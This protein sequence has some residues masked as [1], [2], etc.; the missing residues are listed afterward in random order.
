MSKLLYGLTLAVL[1]SLGLHAQETDP[2]SFSGRYWFDTGY[3]FQTFTPGNL[4][5]S[6]EDLDEGFHTFN[7]YITDGTE[8]SSTHSKW[9]FKKGRKANEN[10]HLKATIY[11][12]G[13]LFST[14]EVTVGAGNII[15]FAL[16]MNAVDLGTHTLGVI[17]TDANGNSLGYRNSVFL[18]VPTD[19]Q[20]STFLAYYYIDNE[21]RGTA[22]PTYDGTVMHLDIDAASLETGLHFLTLYMVSPHGMASSVRSSWFIKIPS[23]GEGIKQYSY[24]LNDNPETLTT[25]NLPEVINPCQVMSLIEIPE[26]PFRSKS[27]KFEI[28]DNKPVY[29]AC[30]D[31]NIRFMDPDSRVSTSSRTY[32]DIRTKYTPD[33]ITSLGLN[34]RINTGV[35]EKD[36]IKLFKFDAE[37]GDSINTSCAKAA[38]M[39]IYS[40]SGK[41]IIQVQ[42]IKATQNCSMTAR[43]NGTY[44]LAVHDV[45]NGYSTELNFQHIHKFALLDQNVKKSADKGCFEMKVIG[46]GFE[47]L[48]SLAIKGDETE[49]E[50]DKFKVV[51]NNTLYVMIDFDQN[52]VEKGPYRLKGIF[53]DNDKKTTEEI[54]SSTALE[55]ESS[56]PV[57]INVRIDTP[58]I[59]S[60][61]Y[62]AYIHVTNNSNVGV[63]GVPFNLAAE[64]TGREGKI[65]FMDFGISVDV[66][67]KDSI[68][69]VYYTENLLNT[70]KS[71][72]FAPTIIPYLAPGETKTYTLGFTTKAHE[73]VNLYAWTGTPWSESIREMTSEN[74]DLSIIEQPF[75]GNLFTFQEACKIFYQWLSGQDTTEAE[76]TKEHNRYA[77][78]CHPDPNLR[79]VVN[80]AAGATKQA[81]GLAASSS[82]N[83]ISIRMEGYRMLLEGCGSNE[84]VEQMLNTDRRMLMVGGDLMAASNTDNNLWGNLESLWHL[85]NARNHWRQ[86]VPPVPT[87]SYTAVDC[88][89]SGDPNDITG[90]VSPSGTNHIGIDVKNVAYTIEFEN[91][92]EIAN[93]PASKIK[94][95]SQLDGTSFDLSSF[96]AD[97]LKIG[98]KEMELPNEQH[99]IRTL[100][101]RPEINSIAELTFD[102]NNTTGEAI[103][104]IRSLDPLT[105]D[106]IS[107]MDDGILPVND[108]N[109]RGVGYLTFSLGLKAGLTDNKTIKT[110]AEI[111]FDN[112][113]PIKTPIWTNI[114]DFKAPAASI[115]SQSSDDNMTFNFTVEGE[116]IGSGVWYYDLYMS[117][118]GTDDWKAVSTHNET[119]I[120][121][122]CSAEPLDNVTF[123]VY[124]VDKAGNRQGQTYLEAILGDVDGNGLIDANDVV[125]LRNH[126]LGRLQQGSISN[127]DVNGDGVIDTQDATAIR[128]NYLDKQTKIIT[129]RINLAK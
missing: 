3:G 13:Q 85:L 118:N 98:N 90:Y 65:E 41:S 59:A 124:A 29:Y 55:V 95:T 42:G 69:V 30:H 16:D 114:T 50:I 68:P 73:I 53:K 74:Y 111:I 66:Q 71:G 102:V 64:H 61:P 36:K 122:Y 96:R 25:V 35:I 83:A 28:E 77:P 91:D 117:T 105:L 92:P 49:V 32:T 100:D 31:F 62:L 97:K 101:M 38:M 12:D 119:E 17:L 93:A 20:Y 46:N 110:Q 34:E 21:F 84:Y 4:E 9:F 67:Y 54:I 76:L 82:S 126:Y 56:A 24:W 22:E 6:T 43:E 94:V 18:R 75:E 87:S 123:A 70:G 107:Y 7:A 72:S 58:R 103:W 109:H 128:N 14:E 19:L 33:N 125:V 5:V 44:Y 80:E 10:E 37:I 45:A 8:I 120:F 57:D 1:T 104:N 51:D 112:N 129:R 81:I 47:S 2:P 27:Y 15:D 40:P 113:P 88:F 48:Q 63:W 116:D 78:Q 121:S 99:F 89:Q 127:A 60:T 26:M 79:D 39:D 106:E 11:V 23:E 108:D 52:N 86:S 115:A